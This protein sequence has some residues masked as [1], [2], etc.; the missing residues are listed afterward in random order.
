M[1]KLQYR[2]SEAPTCWGIVN[3][4]EVPNQKDF[5]RDITNI[6][7]WKEDDLKYFDACKQYN[8]ALELA[9]KNWVPIRVEDQEKVKMLLWNILLETTIEVT[10]DC[11][12][13]KPI[14][15]KLYDIPDSME[16]ELKDFT[17]CYYHDKFITNHCTWC[18]FGHSEK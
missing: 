8:G 10:T 16:F 3:V 9:L 4:P 14:E 5:Y 15:S 13:W 11:Q 17:W 18:G 2:S 12:L 1:N 7:M 6:K